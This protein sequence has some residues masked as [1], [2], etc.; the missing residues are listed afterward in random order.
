MR[1]RL[2]GQKLSNVHPRRLLACVAHVVMAFLSGANACK[3]GM[4]EMLNYRIILF[5]LALC[6]C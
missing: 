1:G 4:S 5:P 2:E 3:S 6:L